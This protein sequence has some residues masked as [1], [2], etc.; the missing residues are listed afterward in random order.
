MKIIFTFLLLSFATVIY[1]QQTIYDTIIH[2]GLQRSFILYIPETYNPGQAAPL[3][4]N[5]HGYSSNA[6]EQMNYGDFRD[7]ADTAG[8]LLVHPMGTLD[9]FGNT[10]WNA[11]WGGE[12]D[13]IGF[14]EALIDSLAAG[15]SI[16]T[17]RVFSTG[18]SNGGFMSYTLACELSNRIAAIASVTGSMN[19]NQAGSCNPQ[20]PVP[21]MEIHGTADFVVPYN[22]NAFM[23]PIPEV[24]TYWTGFNNCVPEPVITEI[25]DIDPNDGC[26]AEKHYYGGGANGVEVIHFKIINGGHTWPGS[27]FPTGGGNTCQD[28][29][30]SVEIWKFF[31]KFDINGLINPTNAKTEFTPSTGLSIWPNPANN[32]VR[33]NIIPIEEGTIRIRDLKGEEVNRVIANGTDQPVINVNDLPAGLYLV[34]FNNVQGKIIFSG[35]VMVQ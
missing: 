22:G 31:S 16:N 10:Y 29:D 20:H 35:K 24:I 6:F 30:A 17:D 2:D 4:I 28:F 32:H 18:M 26:T 7:V 21:V 9:S 33:V 1:G 3:V 15:Y 13:D 11:N 25:P 8:F 27:P 14:T 19:S 5:F 12:V 23:E 34:Q